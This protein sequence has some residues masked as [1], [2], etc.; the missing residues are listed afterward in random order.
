M[1]KAIKIIVIVLLALILIGAVGIS[2]FTGHQVVINSTQLSHAVEK[3]EPPLNVFKSDHLDYEAFTEQYRIENF[4]LTSSLDGHS[5]PV[6]Y[7]S[8]PNEEGRDH[9]TVIMVHGLGGNRMTVFPAAQV[10]LE[11]GYNVLAY[12]QRSSGENQAVRTTFGFLEKFDLLDCAAAVKNWAPEKK[13]GV[14]G[15]SFGGI[16]AVLGVCD[17]SLGLTAQTDFL[18]LDSPISNMEAELRMVMT[19][20]DMGGIPVD[21]LIWTGNIMNKI[22]LGFSYQEADG[23]HVIR[24][25]MQAADSDFPLLVFICGQDDVT[26][27]PQGAD[28]YEIYPGGTKW[29]INFEDSGHAESW[30]DHEAEYREAVETLLT[31]VREQSSRNE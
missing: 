26:P 7:I 6:S 10:F 28:L 5:I 31:A 29:L 30:A 25:R 21:Y 3:I 1:K 18:I 27:Y 11:N 17:S 9:D 15:T 4:T 2:I 16:T 23:R 12:D 13:L 22:E 19:S 8:S 20:E 24:T 14:W